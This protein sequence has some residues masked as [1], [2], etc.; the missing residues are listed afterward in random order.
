MKNKT[1]WAP[2]V[3]FVLIAL[4]TIA[5]GTSSPA[6]PASS[7]EMTAAPA[8]T[9]T[10]APT[11]VPEVLPDLS[12]AQIRLDELPEG[13]E[14]IAADE[15]NMEELNSGDSEFKPEIVF[16]FV[17]KHPFQV[18]FGMNFLLVEAVDRLGFK[19]ALNHPEMAL[20]EFTGGMGST[21]VREEKT[22]EGLE[23]IGDEQI[24]MTMLADVE[25]IPMRLDVV[26]FQR[27]M[28]GG[29]IMSM[30]MEG[31]PGSISIQ[32]LGKLFDQHIQESLKT[33]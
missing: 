25:S 18:V 21:N 11:A 17:N 23:D 30:I 24:A 31:E 28:V 2:T 22:L 15:F 29:M 7:I 10:S 4:V 6:T 13:F 26:M 16:T 27:D 3:A 1:W 19:Y 14:Q 5:C 8:A 33:E 20:K 12:A 9:Q 32:E